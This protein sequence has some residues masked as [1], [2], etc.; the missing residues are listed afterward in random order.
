[1]NTVKNPPFRSPSHDEISQQARE[2]WFA[3]NSPVG[4]DEEIW[5]EAERQL[6]SRL[7]RQDALQ[8]RSTPTGNR[9]GDDETIDQAELQSRLNSVGRTAE[10]SPTALDLT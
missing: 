2:L 4:Q 7:R 10:H 6:L 1:M 8:I 3:R 9:A 5:L